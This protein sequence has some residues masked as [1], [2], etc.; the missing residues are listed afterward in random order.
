VT[1]SPGQGG[2]G[3]SGLASSSVDGAPGESAE[4]KLIDIVEEPDGDAVSSSG[5]N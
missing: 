3:G 5:S 4:E 2:P 1:L